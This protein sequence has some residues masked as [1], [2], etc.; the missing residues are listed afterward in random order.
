MSKLVAS[1][2]V[3][4]PALTSRFYCDLLGFEVVKIHKI[5]NQIHG[6]RLRLGAHSEMMLYRAED[7]EPPKQ[8]LFLKVDDVVGLYNRLSDIR[9]KYPTHWEVTSELSATLF[10]DGEFSIR[11]L[12]GWH[13]T[14]LGTEVEFS[15]PPA[16]TLA[17]N[18]AV[19]G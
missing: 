2:A 13:L 10:G 18:S 1:Y 3:A 14:I 8:N 19:S 5:S 11:D 7:G 15:P 16:Q 6:M 17:E 12:N 4:D 9:E